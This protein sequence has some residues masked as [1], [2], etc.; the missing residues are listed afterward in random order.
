MKSLA[1]PVFESARPWRFALG[2][3]MWWAAAT[4]AQAQ[5]ASVP[6]SA[7]RGEPAPSA[8]SADKEYRLDAARHVYAAFPARVHKGKLPPMMYAVM[9]TDT[10]IDATGQ[11]VN[12]SVARPPASAKE[13]APWVVSLIRGAAPFPAPARLGGA[14]V[15]YRE[16][17]LV[18]KTG[19]FQVDTLTEGQR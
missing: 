5:F 18:D 11:V 17:W 7:V 1:T 16:I 6:P 3:G 10:E 4:A 2:A 12:V 19:L 9:I 13:V 15:T 8:A 14:S